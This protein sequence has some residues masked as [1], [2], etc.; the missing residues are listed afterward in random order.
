MRPLDLASRMR[1][2][3][4]VLVVGAMLAAGLICGAGWG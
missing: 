4:A 3:D 2:A 1:L